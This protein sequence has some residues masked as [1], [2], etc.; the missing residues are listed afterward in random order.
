[1][2]TVLDNFGVLFA[3]VLA[4]VAATIAMHKLV[5]LNNSKFAQ[6]TEVNE[7]NNTL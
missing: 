1:L 7:T 2:D 3:P 4:I 5:N 6:R